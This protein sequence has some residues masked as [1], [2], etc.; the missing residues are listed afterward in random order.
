MTAIS[1]TVYSDTI[2]P[3]CLLGYRKT[4]L[5]IEAAKRQH[6]DLSFSIRYKP[7]ELDATLPVDTPLSKQER[8]ASK[9]GKERFQSMEKMM[10]Q[11]G[12]E[13]GVNFS[14]GGTVRNT[15]RSHRLLER[16]WQSGGEPLQ[17]KALELCFTS[18]FEN[19]GDIGSP[20]NLARIGTEAGLF[21]SDE[22]ALNF[23]HGSAC[24]P[25]VEQSL[26]ESRRL[27]ISGVPFTIISAQ[28]M[29]QPVGVSGAQEPD[30][31]TEIFTAIATGK[32]LS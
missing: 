22:E 30:T 3:F 8:Y 1:L 11:R 13:V 18:Y 6:P 23:I 20:E 14:Y 5:A 7:F 15:I 31:F 17:R 29:K 12:R 2:C 32:T 25:D 16:A 9:F 24:L 28:G 26:T 21:S 4:Q 10:I 19:E 27:G